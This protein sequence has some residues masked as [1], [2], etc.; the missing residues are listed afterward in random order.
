MFTLDV[1]VKSNFW[2]LVY[3]FRMG[4]SPKNEHFFFLPSHT[5][6]CHRSGF[7]HIICMTEILVSVGRLCL[8]SMMWVCGYSSFKSRVN[9]TC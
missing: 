2:L 3:C 4:T 8:V 9:F 7:L 5:V 1:G 6:E